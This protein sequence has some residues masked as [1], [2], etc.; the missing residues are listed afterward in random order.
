[1]F[2]GRQQHYDRDTTDAAKL[3]AGPAARTTPAGTKEPGVVIRYD[4]HRIK[5]LL[6]VPEALRLANEIADA[7]EEHDNRTSREVNP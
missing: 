6:P 5:Y 7:V 1:M 3:S 4:A 2:I